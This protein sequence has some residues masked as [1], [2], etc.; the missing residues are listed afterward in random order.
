[1]LLNLF[2]PDPPAHPPTWLI[3]CSFAFQIRA[4]LDCQRML[5]RN[6]KCTSNKQPSKLQTGGLG[7]QNQLSNRQFDGFNRPNQ[8][9]PNRVEIYRNTPF[10]AV[11]IAS[12]RLWSGVSHPRRRTR[13]ATTVES[14]VL[15]SHVLLLLLL[16]RLL[17]RA[18]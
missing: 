12:M 15:G 4:L 9:T 14:V 13:E 3:N 8:T 2:T 18:S 11:I 17:G 7:I 1:M 16:L 6:T 5:G 10:A